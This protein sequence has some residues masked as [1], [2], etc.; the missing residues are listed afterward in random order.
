MEA[1]VVKQASEIK[2][3]DGRSKI[4]E[5]EWKRKIWAESQWVEEVARERIG[6]LQTMEQEEYA[7]SV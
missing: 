5:V 3:I 2:S 4:D 6:M 7:R 1:L